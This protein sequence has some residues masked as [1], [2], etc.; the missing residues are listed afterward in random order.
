MFDA[1]FTLSVL[2]I[3]LSLFLGISILKM[4]Q[5]KLKLEDYEFEVKVLKHYLAVNRR[6]YDE[7]FL[8]SIHSPFEEEERETTNFWS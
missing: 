6:Q 4:A 2:I 3:V 8:K 1:V 7:L 5:Y